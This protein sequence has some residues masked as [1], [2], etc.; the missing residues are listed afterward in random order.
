MHLLDQPDIYQGC[1]HGLRAN[2]FLV[3]ERLQVVGVSACTEQYEVRQRQDVDL[4][5]RTVLRIDWDNHTV[6]M[7]QVSLESVAS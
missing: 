7:V 5:R 2:P 6:T 4:E 3:D 1:S